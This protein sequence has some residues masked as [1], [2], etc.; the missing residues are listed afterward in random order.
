MGMETD[1]EEEE[2]TETE[3]VLRLLREEGRE[4]VTGNLSL[5]EDISSFVEAGAGIRD[6]DEDEFDVRGL[7]SLDDE[8]EIEVV[9]DRLRFCVMLVVD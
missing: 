8:V 4:R 5:R 6:E 3:T 9:L 1:E 2:E 7:A